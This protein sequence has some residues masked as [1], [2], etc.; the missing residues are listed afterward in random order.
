MVIGNKPRSF[1]KV[2][3]YQTDDDDDD[4][5]EMRQKD[6]LCSKRYNADQHFVRLR[7]FHKKTYINMRKTVKA[8]N[9]IFMFK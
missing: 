4:D 7:L 1:S 6:D 2:I 9:N 5:E 8:K 3:G